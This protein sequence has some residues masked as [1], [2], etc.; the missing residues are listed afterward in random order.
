MKKLTTNPYRTTLL[1]Y[2][3]FWP[4]AF[5]ISEVNSIVDMHDSL[6]IPATVGLG[7]TDIDHSF[8]KSQTTFCYPNNTN[9]WIFDKLFHLF[10]R[11]NN[12]YFDFD[13]LGFESFQYTKYEPGEY[14][15]YHMDTFMGD[16]GL[17]KDAILNRKLSMSILLNDPSEF[18]GGDFQVAIGN[19]ETP[20]SYTLEKGHA[21][22]FPSF[23][24]H[25]VTPITRGIRKSL[26]V[27]AL[28]PKF[29]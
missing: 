23:L 21:I 19:P 15:N 13:L 3:I 10:E 20:H 1:P 11:T 12:E 24:L 22:F 26:V 29:K 7:G 17:N 6:V 28:G 25:R 4:N 2:A 16:C 27:W 5:S 9:Q 8:R 14:Y 18:D